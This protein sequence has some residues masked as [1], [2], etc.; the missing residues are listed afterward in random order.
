MNNK[1]VQKK[2]LMELQ[3]YRFRL[4]RQISRIKKLYVEGDLTKRE[5]VNLLIQ[6]YARINSRIKNESKR[7]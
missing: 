3:I 4:K 5:F 7:S 1:T 2:D 6:H